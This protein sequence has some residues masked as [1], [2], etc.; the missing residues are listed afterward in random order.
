MKK[1]DVLLRACSI[2]LSLQGFSLWTASISRKCLSKKVSLTFRVSQWKQLAFLYTSLYPCLTLWMT[3]VWADL[4]ILNNPCSLCVYFPSPPKS[5][6]LPS[7]QSPA[8]LS[9]HFGR[10]L[11][12]MSSQYPEAAAGMER[13]LTQLL[14]I[15]AS[16][17]DLAII[18]LCFSRV[19]ETSP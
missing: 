8:W 16:D 4:D 9:F 14:R 5:W 13:G 1:N 19:L 2:V 6:S 18:K 11:L 15:T 12:L 7:T 3:A 10:V 17:L